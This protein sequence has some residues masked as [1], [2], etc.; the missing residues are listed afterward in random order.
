MKDKQQAM[1][2]YE[3]PKVEPVEVE[4]ESGFATSAHIG[5]ITGNSWNEQSGGS[6]GTN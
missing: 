2:G 3:A 4:I 1:P 5:S 6:L